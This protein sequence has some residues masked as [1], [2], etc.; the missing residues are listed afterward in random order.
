VLIIEPIT[1]II[2]IDAPGY[3][4]ERIRIGSMAPRDVRFFVVEPEERASELISVIFNV[5]PSSA[6]LFVNGQMIETNQAVQLTSGEKQIRIERAGYQTIS[7]LITINERNIQFNY[8]MQET[9]DIP[10]LF[11]INNSG[12]TVF[13]NGQERGRT[14][15]SG[16]LGLWLFPGSYAAEIRQ[17]G[18]LTQIIDIEVSAERNNRFAIQLEKNVGE[19]ILHT[20]P[21]DASVFINR[22]DYGIQQRLELAP[23]LYRL[24]VVKEGFEPYLENLEIS[25]NDQITRNIRLTAH[26]GSLRF[27]V[28]PAIAGVHLQDNLGNTI[29]EWTGFQQLR[30]L[31]VGNYLLTAT[32]EGYLTVRENIRINKDD[33][34]IKDIMMVEGTDTVTSN[35]NDMFCGLNMSLRNWY[36]A[37]SR[38][39]AV[40]SLGIPPTFSSFVNVLNSENRIRIFHN[41]L[42]A[43]EGLPVVVPT[44]FENF[45]PCFI[46][47][48]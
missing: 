12:A 43:M 31:Q 13:I 20:T 34:T 36:S 16:S 3:M 44:E 4:Q 19:L 2:T 8:M 29:Q 14:D 18:F 23:G 6:D 9:E 37:L 33:I 45:Y 40:R 42:L 7:D 1:Q 41:Q 30:N 17:P 35:H 39:D 27:T 48:R 21:A 10:V 46:N 26:T 32:A 22:Q 25:L 5:Q 24:E 11:E 15:S 47:D 38:N 28:V